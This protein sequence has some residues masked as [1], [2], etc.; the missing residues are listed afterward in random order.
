M[1]DATTNAILDT[2]RCVGGDQ[3]V[4][5]VT[6]PITTIQGIPVDA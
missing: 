6:V 4:V 5:Y 3:G 2:I 1:M